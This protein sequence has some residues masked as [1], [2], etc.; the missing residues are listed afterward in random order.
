MEMVSPSG[1]M[2]LPSY[3]EATDILPVERREDEFE[4]FLLNA[5]PGQATIKFSRG[6]LW[7]D[8]QP[9]DSE[10][11]EYLTAHQ[12]QCLGNPEHAL[13]KCLVD[14]VMRLIANMTPE[15]AR[16]PYSTP[17]RC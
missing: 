4:R 8:L 9:T 10:V 6:V 7:D 13:K 3:V 14:K 11:R 1:L 16:G 17:N 2:I 12:K 15:N 5:K